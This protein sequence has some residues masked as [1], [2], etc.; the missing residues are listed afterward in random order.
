MRRI[1]GVQKLLTADDTSTNSSRRTSM[2]SSGFG[3]RPPS[4]PS[5]LRQD[6]TPAREDRP[7]EV[8]RRSV[9]TPSANVPPRPPTLLGSRRR[10]SETTRTF[11]GSSTS[12]VKPP[13]NRPE[14]PE[15]SPSP[16][17][18]PEPSY[19]THSSI[20]MSHGQNQDIHSP[21]FINGVQEQHPD[22]HAQLERMATSELSF[23]SSTP[24]LPEPS[25]QL[26]FE[27]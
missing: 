24:S 3:G 15:P 4:R 26:S 21:S 18:S 27:V 23:D 7:S 8:L 13:V 9:T 5:L 11:L 12:T 10:Q 2:R 14:I 1:S 20:N 17:L 22:A 6:S 19:T 16:P 25:A